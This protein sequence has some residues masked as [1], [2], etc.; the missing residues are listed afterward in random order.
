MALMAST[1]REVDV[2]NYPIWLMVVAPILALVLQ[3]LITV[4]FPRFDY[5][6]LPLL[7]TI[8]FG[9]TWRN[10]IGGGVFGAVIGILQDAITQHPLGV[11]GIG[12]SIVGY[13]A[14][15]MGIRIDTESF[16]T[17][18]VLLPVFTLLQ[19]AIVWVLERRVI[20]QPYAWIWWQEGIRAV[21]SAL[22]GLMLF[23]LLDKARR[24]D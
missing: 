20:E 19:G 9:I 4:H 16:F 22:L 24:R 15:S 8:Y 6:D 1:R 3:S 12:K 17:R 18:L 21:V 7:V 23:A 10:P 13:V 11:F 2:P 14:A 5:V